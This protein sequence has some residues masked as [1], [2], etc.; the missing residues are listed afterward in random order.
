MMPGNGA[1][2]H[3]GRVQPCTG[4]II[5]GMVRKERLELSRVAPLE[6]KSSASTSSATLAMKHVHAFMPARA[7]ALEPKGERRSRGR[8]KMVGRVG[9]EPTTN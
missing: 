7:C 4:A 1:F 8:E 6:P 5:V 3:W 2:R 9:F